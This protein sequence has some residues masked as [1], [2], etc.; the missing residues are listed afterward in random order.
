MRARIPQDVDLEDRLAFGLTPTR[1]GYLAL[2]ALAAFTVWTVRWA[3]W[4]VRA[5]AALPVV[6]AGAGLA[7]G[8]WHGRGLDHWAA[9]LLVYLARFLHTRARGWRRPPES[10]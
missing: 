2:A 5:L 10:P 8:R 7:W 9:D 1:F 3:P 4:P 6:G